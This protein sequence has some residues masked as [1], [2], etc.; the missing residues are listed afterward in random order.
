MKHSEAYIEYSKRIN[1]QNSELCLGGNWKDVLNFWIYI[2]NISDKQW[3][4]VVKRYLD[5]KFMVRNIAAG[6]VN[7]AAVAATQCVF[8][9][10]AA[11][12]AYDV[13]YVASCSNVAA[14]AASFAAVAASFA[15]NELIGSDILLKQRKSL[16]FLPMFIEL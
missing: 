15:T 12:A 16:T 8:V 11:A 1:L 13:A 5:T 2:D 14:V 10:D 7:A 3:E 4:I 9:H 6:S